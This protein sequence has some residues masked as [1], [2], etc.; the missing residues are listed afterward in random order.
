MDRQV[1]LDIL[2]TTEIFRGAPASALAEIRASA[3]RKTVGADE[4]LFRQGDPAS[5][6]YIVVTGRLRRARAVRTPGSAS[7]GR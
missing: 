3:A 6:F 2:G 1:D 4:A 5:M 7:C